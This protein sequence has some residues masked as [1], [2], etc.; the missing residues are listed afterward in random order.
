MAKSVKKAVKKDAKSEEI[1][2]GFCTAEY[3]AK[4]YSISERRVR[5]LR[6][7][8]A[9]VVEQT[10]V[11]PRYNVLK[12]YLQ[13]GLYLQKKLNTAGERQRALTA[14]ADYKEKRVELMDLELRKRRG[15]LHEAR[16]VET[17]ITHNIL[18]ARAAF[19]A[20]PGRIAQELAACGSANEINVVLRKAIIAILNE[21]SEKKYDAAEFDRLVKEEGDFIPDDEDDE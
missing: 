2:N 21:L 15:E 3:L 18:T 8:G 13:Y 9:F 6:S 11:G 19:L 14:D 4:Q 5:Q 7:D 20:L 17:I 1:E 16:H 12:S 10:P